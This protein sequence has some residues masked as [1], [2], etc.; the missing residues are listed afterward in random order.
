[1]TP[2]EALLEARQHG[3]S[4]AVIDGA[5]RVRADGPV[6]V[7]VLEH[8]RI[9]KAALVQM[10]TLNPTTS[11]EVPGVTDETEPAEEHA[12]ARPC[13]NCKLAMWWQRPQR[14][15]GGWVCGVCHPDPEVLMRDGP[16]P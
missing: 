11:A 2:V 10:M 7:V 14:K 8:L 4:I 3:V 15:D 9:H 1:V 6:P 13:P 12:P 16:R 5:M